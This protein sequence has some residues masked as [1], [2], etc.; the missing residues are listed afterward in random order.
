MNLSDLTVNNFIEVLDYALGSVTD[1]VKLLI[2]EMEASN[3]NIDAAVKS[4]EP[5]EIFP[6]SSHKCFAFESYVTREIFEGFSVRSDEDEEDRFYNFSQFKELRSLSTTDLLNRN[7]RSPF[8]K[9]ARA[10]Y[11]RVV[12]PKMELSFYG[13]LGQRRTLNEWRFPTTAFFGAFAEMAR[14]VWILRCLALSFDEEVSVFRVRRGCRFSSVYMES[15]VAEEEEED[16]DAGGGEVAVAF[17]VVPGF[18]IG[19][20]VVQSQVDLG[21]PNRSITDC[22]CPLWEAYLTH[23]A[24]VA[25]GGFQYTYKDEAR[26]SYEKEYKIAFGLQILKESDGIGMLNFIDQISFLRLIIDLY[27][28]NPRIDGVYSVNTMRKLIDSSSIPLW[29]RLFAGPTL[30]LSRFSALFGELCGEDYRLLNCF[31]TE[32]SKTVDHVLLNCN[33]AQKVLNVAFTYEFLELTQP[34]SREGNLS[35][36]KWRTRFLRADQG[37]VQG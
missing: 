25:M 23:L 10:K 11:M 9:F 16:G 26:N 17:T 32:A 6:K 5:E 3:W 1:F 2:C 28:F 13:D 24:V 12:H 18:K 15:V 8:A 21:N 27:N 37:Q 34:S 19:K 35:K 33:F 29:V 30:F 14:R 31:I 22:Q 20:T 4:I 36:T 7:P